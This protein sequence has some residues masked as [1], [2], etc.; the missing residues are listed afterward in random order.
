MLDDQSIE[1]PAS[2]PLL[3]ENEDFEFENAVSE[4]IQNHHSL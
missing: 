1:D 2:I 4:G 3:Q